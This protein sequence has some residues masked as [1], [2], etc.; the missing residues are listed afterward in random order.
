[1]IAHQKELV[2]VRDCARSHLAQAVAVRLALKVKQEEIAAL[3]QSQIEHPDIIQGYTDALTKETQALFA[4]FQGYISVYAPEYG[5]GHLFNMSTVL[6]ATSIM[7]RYMRDIVDVLRP[8]LGWP[9]GGWKRSLTAHLDRLFVSAKNSPLLRYDIF[10]EKFRHVKFLDQLR[11]VII[12]NR[13]I[14]DE[15][16][17]A[18]CGIDPQNRQKIPVDNELWG[19]PSKWTDPFF[20]RTPEEFI[21]YFGLGGQVQLPI[22]KVFGLLSECFMFIEDVSQ[23]SINKL[24]EHGSDSERDKKQD[25]SG[26]S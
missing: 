1:M 2:R 8:V 4:N 6:L 7:D 9:Q 22:D 14:I 12:H 23:I 13:G 18:Q 10:P 3:A 25:S 26:K 19:L 21:S 17:Y 20:T 5:P 11:H 24:S 15:K 16:F